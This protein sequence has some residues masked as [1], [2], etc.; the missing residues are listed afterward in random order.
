M[1]HS[2][3]AVIPG[4]ML[5]PERHLC[6]YFTVTRK[7]SSTMLPI[8]WNSLVLDRGWVNLLQRNCGIVLLP[9]TSTRRHWKF[10]QRHILNCWRKDTRTSGYTTIVPQLTWPWWGGY[11]VSDVQILA[12]QGQ[13]TE[14]LAALRLAADEGWQSLWWYY[15]RHDPNL[16]SIRVEPEFQLILNRIEDDMSAQMQRIREMEQ[17]GE[18]ATIPG[19]NFASK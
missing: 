1:K 13:K 6:R 5:D 3:P 7:I 8:R 2:L 15:L 16:D 14:A 19:V 17:N 12:L 9:P 18:I 10:I 4:G 11:W